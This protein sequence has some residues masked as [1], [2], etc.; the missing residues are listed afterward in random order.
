M[1][2]VQV[3]DVE[4][5]VR[6]LEFMSP[7]QGNFFL[8]TINKTQVLEVAFLNLATNHIGLSK[9]EEKILSKYKNKIVALASKNYKHT[10]KR[11]I[12]TQK[13]GFLPVLLPVLRSIVTSFLTR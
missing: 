4:A 7:K 8:R 3:V 5:L 12:I 13:G 6:L 11:K 10:E 9:T 1:M 2:D